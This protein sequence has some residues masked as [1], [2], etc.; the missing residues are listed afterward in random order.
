MLKLKLQRAATLV[1]CL[2]GERERWHETVVV[3]DNSFQYLPGDCLLSVAFLSYMG[4]FVS[5]YRDE[6]IASWQQEVDFQYLIKKAKL[7]YTLF[8]QS[9]SQG[10]WFST[11]FSLINFLTDPTTVREWNIH[12]L[13][14]DSFSTENGIII[15]RG[16]K[17]PLVID[18]QCQAQKWIKS[19]EDKN[20]L[21]VTDLGL[22]NYMSTVEKAVRNGYPLLLQNILEEIDPSLSSVLSKAVVKQGGQELIKIDDRLISYNNNFRMFITTKLN[23]PHYPPEISTKTIIVNFAVKEQGL[24]AQLLGIAVREEKPQLEE[25]KDKLVTNIATGILFLK[26]LCL[27]IMFLIFTPIEFL[28]DL[29]K[30]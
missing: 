6:L 30:C 26:I 5:N 19:M 1:E 18:P 2:A 25:Q 12:G 9:N 13:P 21:L 7:I 29:V 4:P 20:E 15:T 11:G 28:V 22:S 3:L 23:N 14:A 17:W 16:S 8:F 10:V 27:S 24:E